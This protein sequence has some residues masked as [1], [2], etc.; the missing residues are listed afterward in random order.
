LR[1]HVPDV[2]R[3]LEQG[4]S[5]AAA[6][7]S[8]DRIY[9]IRCH[10]GLAKGD[11]DRFYLDT[12]ELPR[13]VL[14]LSNWDEAPA[15]ARLFLQGF[16]SEAASVADCEAARRHLIDWLLTHGQPEMAQIVR[17]FSSFPFGARTDALD[18]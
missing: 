15:A 5:V 3:E 9:L 13:V 14:R 1:S 10:P 16:G 11:G 2:V 4:G 8:G 18:V 12:L 7:Q 6:W 17:H